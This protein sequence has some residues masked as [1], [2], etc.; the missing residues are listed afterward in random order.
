MQRI[1]LKIV[2]S[3]QKGEIL[4]IY[5]QDA[6]TSFL[7]ESITCIQHLLSVPFVLRLFFRQIHQTNIPAKA[8]AATDPNTAPTMIAIAPIKRDKLQ[9]IFSSDLIIKD[10]PPYSCYGIQSE[11]TQFL[12]FPQILHFTVHYRFGTEQAALRMYS[13]RKRQRIQILLIQG[14]NKYGTF[15]LNIIRSLQAFKLHILIG[16]SQQK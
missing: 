11:R 7:F 5:F 16:Y 13:L 14:K 3:P 10:L 2:L 15:M 9:M 4:K 12:F 6:K 1:V 8:S